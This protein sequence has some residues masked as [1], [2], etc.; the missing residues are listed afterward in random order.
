MTAHQQ[1]LT[2]CESSSPLAFVGTVMRQFREALA[3]S[4]E[5]RRLARELNQFDDRDLADLRLQRHDI[6]RLARGLPVP[7][8]EV[9]RHSR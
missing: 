3:S 6:D 2:H 5:R 1:V 9:W 8:M 7:A 4:L